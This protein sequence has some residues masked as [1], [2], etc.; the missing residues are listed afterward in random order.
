[1]LH[2]ACGRPSLMVVLCLENSVLF[3]NIIW[4]GLAVRS[5]HDSF[6][7]WCGRRS[8]DCENKAF[9]HPFRFFSL[10][11]P[12]RTAWLQPL[13]SFASYFQL[14]RS[15]LVSFRSLSQAS[16][17]RSA[18]RPA[19]CC[20]VDCSLYM[21]S[22]IIR[23]SFIQWTWPGFRTRRWQ[24]RRRMFQEWLCIMLK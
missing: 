9:W 11:I 3:L 14:P 16:L 10:F 19:G 4:S 15:M 23:P 22:F 8:F 1:M 7:C 6:F 13:R 18:G 17:E 24:T 12:F 20:P 2:P 5:L 21:M